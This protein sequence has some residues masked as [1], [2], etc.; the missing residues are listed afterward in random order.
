MQNFLNAVAPGYIKLGNPQKCFERQIAVN[1]PPPPYY[2]PTPLALALSSPLFP[3]KIT[4]HALVNGWP[5]RVYRTPLHKKKLQP[6]VVAKREETY[7]Y[8]KGRAVVRARVVRHRC[9]LLSLVYRTRT[10]AREGENRRSD[11]SRLLISEKTEYESRAIVYYRARN[12]WDY[13][14]CVKLNRESGVSL[15]LPRP[16]P[17]TLLSLAC[18]RFRYLYLHTLVYGWREKEREERRIERERETERRSRVCTRGYIQWVQLAMRAAAR[19]EPPILD[20]GWDIPPG[21][22]FLSFSPSLSLFLNCLLSR[23]SS[24]FADDSIPVIVRRLLCFSLS[25]LCS[26]L[27]TP[28]PLVVHQAVRV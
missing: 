21:H 4:Y 18:S 9:V 17:P 1:C 16:T 27:Y 26:L 20:C 6:L 2:T 28:Q 3:V 23:A 14:C 19:G 13:S 8:K 7:M 11:L 5:A 10:L 22:P 12:G 15:S 25:L 24:S